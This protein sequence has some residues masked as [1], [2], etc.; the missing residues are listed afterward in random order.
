MDKKIS[1]LPLASSIA[2]T[3]YVPIV[4]GGVTKKVLASAFG[5]SPDLS[6][7]IS[8]DGTSPATTG[9]IDIGIGQ[10]VG[11]EDDSAQLLLI[12]DAPVLRGD[13]RVIFDADEGFYDFVN[14]TNKTIT[15]NFDSAT[16]DREVVWQD[17]YYT[18]VADL[19]DISTAVGAVVVSANATATN[20]SII[21]VVATATI[22]DPSPVEGRGF[23]VLVRNG[24]A[25][26]GGTGYAIAGTIIKRTFHSGAWA[27]YVYN[28]VLYLTTMEREALDTNADTQVFVFDT[29]LKIYYAWSTD[30]WIP[31]GSIIQTDPNLEMPAIVDTPANYPV[32]NVGA[33]TDN[34]GTPIIYSSSDVTKATVDSSGNVTLIGPTGNVTITASQA[35]GSGYS[36]ATVS[37]T[38]AIND[39]ILV[40]LTTEASITPTTI[41][42]TISVKNN[43][44]AIY[45][46]SN[47]NPAAKHGIVTPVFNL[48]VKI[49]GTTHTIE[50]HWLKKIFLK[51]SPGDTIALG[52][53]VASDVQ[54][55]ELYSESIAA[56]SLRT[57]TGTNISIN[58]DKVSVGKFTQST[59]H[60]TFP[61][62]KKIARFISNG[63]SKYWI[64]YREFDGATWSKQQYLTVPK[65]TDLTVEFT[66]RKV[67]FGTFDQ[68]AISVNVDSATVINRTVA[69][70]CRYTIPVV[71]GISHLCY[72]NADVAAKAAIAV[73][74]DEIVF[75][76]SG[77]PYLNL[78]L[79]AP[80]FTANIAAGK[81]GCEGIIIRGQIV[82]GNRPIIQPSFVTGEGVGG[83][84]M[85]CGGATQ[86]TYWK[87][88]LLDTTIGGKFYQIGGLWKVIN[89][90]GGG[91]DAVHNSDDI[92]G[93]SVGNAPNLLTIDYFDCDL[94]DSYGDIWNYGGNTA[95]GG[96][97][98]TAASKVEMHNC[99]GRRAGGFQN[100][101]CMTTHANLD[102]FSFGCEYEDAF[103][104]VVGHETSNNSISWHAFDTLSRGTRKCEAY[105]ANFYDCI[106]ENT[107]GMGNIKGTNP[108]FFNT[109]ITSNSAAPAL[110]NFR[111]ITLCKVESNIFDNQASIAVGIFYSGVAANKEISR[112]NLFLNYTSS[113]GAIQ[114]SNYAGPT[115]NNVYARGNT[116]VGCVL[117]MNG[118]DVYNKLYVG[119]NACKTNGTSVKSNVAPGDTLYSEGHNVCDPTVSA[120]AHMDGSDVTTTDAA[121]DSTYRPTVGGNVDNGT[122]DNTLYS[123]IIGR[124]DPEQKVHIMAQS[125][126]PIGAFARLAYNA[127]AIIIPETY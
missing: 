86:Y 25:T 46:G 106:Y 66:C 21:H 15:H 13:S 80:A 95:G 8:L 54:I 31:I 96:V 63:T 3:E 98:I 52:C 40:N 102:V 49:N 24:T 18:G 123:G 26:V 124:R 89:V 9:Q 85:I 2:G 119:N 100:S 50:V 11:L 39:P 118:W 4:Q 7:K 99:S 72:T 90:S 73:S 122:G 16:V 104:D 92:I 47:P 12:P 110:G 84:A 56:T 108:Y 34:V 77:S 74:G 53:A 32:F 19:T 76:Y 35:S 61:Y 87:D 88:L 48:Y 23:T 65:S 121:I 51:V 114:V 29:D 62:N 5:G 17:K 14:V 44:L 112:G 43:C 71:T 6:S 27:S 82:G 55:C 109:T 67:Q 97:A 105:Q 70:E 20:D 120:N 38:F 42:K 116:F 33:T 75:M 64:S 117:A 58:S 83:L 22:T 36:G 41:V 107:G 28:S 111:S 125:L 93:A 101:Q 59:P 78:T 103:L 10:G 45:V 91:V 60:I 68:A 37:R 94:A 126:T 81:K 79:N 69:E 115:V 1:E 30:Q 57:V 113:S 127:A